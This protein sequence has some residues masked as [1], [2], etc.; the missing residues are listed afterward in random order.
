[1]FWA[2]RFYIDGSCEPE[3][4]MG[5]SWIHS[6]LL[7]QGFPSCEP[8]FSKVAFCGVTFMCWALYALPPYGSVLVGVQ[9]TS[10]I[11][12]LRWISVMLP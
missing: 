5:L 6:S 4:A 10:A 8:T 3:P 1:V 11:R 9:V 12:L 7:F 2:W